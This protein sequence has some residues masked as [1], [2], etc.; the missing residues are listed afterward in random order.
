MLW[1]GANDRERC[2]ERAR[3]QERQSTQAHDPYVTFHD[4]VS[5]WSRISIQAVLEARNG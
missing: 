1:R 5:A 4:K 3:R 2:A